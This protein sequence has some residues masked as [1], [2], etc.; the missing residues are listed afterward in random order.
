[1]IGY[2]DIFTVHRDKCRELRK[3]AKKALIYLIDL[4]REGCVDGSL[5]V[6]IGDYYR[7]GTGYDPI[8]SKALEYYHRAVDVGHDPAYLLLYDFWQDQDDNDTY[9]S[10]DDNYYD[11]KKIQD[12]KA[13]LV[14]LEAERKGAKHDGILNQVISRLY[15]MEEDTLS[16]EC[17]GQFKTKG[18]LLLHYS[19]LLI[20]R[21]SPHGY[22]WKGHIY[23]YG[24]HGGNRDPYKA[25][26][27]WEE[28]DKLGLASFMTYKQDWTGLIYV[29]MY[30]LS[31]MHSILSLR[32][33]L[34]CF[35]SSP[36]PLTTS[37][38]I[39]VPFLYVTLLV[40]RTGMGV[41]QNGVKALTYCEKALELATSIE[42]QCTIYRGKLSPIIGLNYYY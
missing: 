15:E 22:F 27:I 12:D 31:F 36:F 35:I 14:L 38:Y 42:Q 16:E 9:D 8:V 24:M 28:A 39:F 18:E 3:D 32:Y 40:Y 26:S 34:V 21:Q 6:M 13:L 33:A 25:V 2:L 30:V 20:E 19:D 11:N 5:F 1:M 29:Y 4:E 17:L 41:T 23:L 37:T 7:D 10:D